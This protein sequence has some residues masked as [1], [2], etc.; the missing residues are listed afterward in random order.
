MIV[1]I[2]Q[3]CSNCV[4]LSNSPMMVVVICLEET[5]MEVVNP[6]PCP[7]LPTSE[8]IISSTSKLT[9]AT[10]IQEASCCIGNIFT[11]DI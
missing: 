10:C 5:K 9:R 6:S 8:K 7:Q 4:S 3:P 2:Y 11:G 1:K